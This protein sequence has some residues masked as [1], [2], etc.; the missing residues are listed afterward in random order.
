LATIALPDPPSQCRRSLS[1]RPHTPLTSRFADRLDTT[2]ALAPFI[3]PCVLR[4]C[5]SV[6]AMTES[7]LARLGRYPARKSVLRSLGR[8]YPTL[9]ATTDS[10]A[11]PQASGALCLRSRHPS[12]QVA[13]SPCWQEALPGVISENLSLDA[14]TLTP[15]LFL[16][17]LPVTSQET[18]AFTLWQQARQHATLR[19]AT[20]V[21]WRLRGC[22]HSIIFRPPGLLATQVAPTAESLQTR[23]SRGVYVR[24]SHGLF[25]PRAPDMLA[26]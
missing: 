6:P 13:A 2:P 16:V 10:C 7:P 8:R 22:S 15:A 12:S 20:S 1:A 4:G 14:W 25:P 24:A 11:R 9:I 5:S 18:S 26:V 3:R 19:T 21:R 23:G 17:H